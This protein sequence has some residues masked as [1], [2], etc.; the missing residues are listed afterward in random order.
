MGVPQASPLPTYEQQADV[1]QAFTV[2]V[3]YDK[4]HALTTE[5]HI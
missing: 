1:S 5:T 4:C 2:R 3:T